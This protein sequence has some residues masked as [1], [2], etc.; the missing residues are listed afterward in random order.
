MF[1]N[2]F[3][4]LNVNF[5]YTKHAFLFLFNHY[6]IFIIFGELLSEYTLVFI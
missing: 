6:L 1:L 4:L 3:T 2:S 5:I